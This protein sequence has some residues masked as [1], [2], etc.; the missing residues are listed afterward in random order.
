MPLFSEVVEIIHN[1]L[2]AT[3]KNVLSIKFSNILNLGIDNNP[4]YNYS[5]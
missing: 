4:F 5:R 2:L 1:K 3:I